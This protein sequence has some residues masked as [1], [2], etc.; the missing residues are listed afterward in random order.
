MGLFAT[1]S[2]EVEVRAVPGFSLTLTPARVVLDYGSVSMVAAFAVGIVREAG[3]NKTVYLDLA[4]MA[5]N[6]SFDRD[7]FVP[8]V[9]APVTLT[10]DADGFSKG[11][12][13]PFDVVGYDDLSDRPVQEPE[14]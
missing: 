14:A 13:A 6:W 5:G 11:M 10:I 2:G 4:G 7:T 9:D 1:V 12:I 8:G 3:H